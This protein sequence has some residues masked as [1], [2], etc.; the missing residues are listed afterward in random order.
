[1]K[2]IVCH[3]VSTFRHILIDFLMN[4]SENAAIEIG[5]FMFRKICLS[6]LTF[7]FLACLFI[8]PTFA[9]TT[10]CLKGKGENLFG[11]NY[12]WMIGDG[13]VFV[14]KRNVQKVSTTED[15]GNPAKWTSKYGSVTFNQYGRENPMGG[16]NEAGLVVELM[17]LDDTVYPKADKRP[18][19]DVLE[20]IQ[21]Q[22]DT[23]ATVAEVLKNTEALRVTSD[24][25]IHYL[26][27]DK[28][29]NTATIEFLDGKL[30]AHTGDKLAVST[31]TNDTYEK[32]LDFTE[33]TPLE[34][35]KTDGSL[36]R[37][38][39]ASQKTKEFQKQPK[40]EQEAV[41]YAF[42]ILADVAQK[43]Y[44]SKD[45]QTQWSIVYDQK[46]GKIY[47]RTLQ[48]PTIKIV[49][50][51]A[52][53]YACG[54]TVKMFDINAKDTG[55]VT[56]KFTGYTRK[57][58]RDLIERSFSGTPFLK[59]VPP[60]LRTYAAGYPEKFAC[61]SANQNAKAE[62]FENPFLTISPFYPYSVLTEL[63]LIRQNL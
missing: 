7:S 27:N 61:S 26:I 33:K 9:C 55:D 47:F 30:V 45:S 39:R 25:K 4:L 63:S 56:A 6:L 3:K 19:V 34:K 51:K 38:A 40:T 22:L 48:S 16:M 43:G 18:T 53:D 17:W 49:D 2:T 42:D 31:L 15:A 24:I 11:R 44:S 14:N 23:A 10:F 21:Y 50:A 36:D 52:F 8:N 5:G 28:D 12:D 37:F 59:D 62:R 1:M 60:M 41:N 54:T 29:G 20:W 13:I 32:S 35:A 57:A 58:N 46:R